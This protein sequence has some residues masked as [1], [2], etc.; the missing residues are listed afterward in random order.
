MNADGSDVTKTPL[1]E[2]DED[3]TET[4]LLLTDLVVD[5]TNNALIY[6]NEKG[7]EITLLNDSELNEQFGFTYD[8]ESIISVYSADVYNN[9]IYITIDNGIH[10][11]EEDMGWRYSYKRTKTIAFKYDLNQRKR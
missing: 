5:H 8:E 11:S 1:S 4:T 9:N 2:V 10:N 6:T 3:T 7:E